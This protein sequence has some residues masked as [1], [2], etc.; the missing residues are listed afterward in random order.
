LERPSWR[1]FPKRTSGESGR[2]PLLCFPAVRELVLPDRIEH[3]VWG[4]AEDTW[5]DVYGALN[6][7][8][9]GSES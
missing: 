6:W 4:T 5:R 1:S 2:L 9:W 8:S 3:G 7:E